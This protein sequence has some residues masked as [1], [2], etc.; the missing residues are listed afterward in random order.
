MKREKFDVVQ[1][2]RNFTGCVVVEPRGA[3]GGLALL[4][5]DF[6]TL[7]VLSS[8]ARIVDVEVTAADHPPFFLTWVYGDP[9][10]HK[11]KEVWD[12]ITSI[13]GQRQGYKLQYTCPLNY[14]LSSVADFIDRG[15]RTWRMDL[16][17]LY[18]QPSDREAI[19]K[20]PLS[21]FVA[22]DKRI[23]GPLPN[24][25][26]SVKS[27][28]Q[29]LV[30]MQDEKEA[31]NASSSR[32]RNWDLVPDSIWKHIWAIRTLPKIKTFIWHA[33][34]EGLATGD[35]LANRKV[36]IDPVCARCGTQ[37]ETMGHLLFE[38]SF[39]RAIWFGSSLTHSPSFTSAPSL[40]EWL[41]GWDVLFRKDKGLARESLA[42]ASF[43]CWYIWRA[44]NDMAH[45]PA[46]SPTSNDKACWALPPVGVLKAN[47]DAVLT[48]DKSRGGLGVIFR[49]HRGVQMKALSI[50]FHL[51]SVLQ[52]EAA[53]VQSALIQALE[54]GH[55]RLQVEF[56]SKELLSFLLDPNRV[57]PSEAAIM[58][59]DVRRLVAS[60]MSI[61]FL[62]IPRDLNSI[63]DTLARK[64]L[65]IMCK[66]DW[67][68][69]IPW[70]HTLC[71]NEATGCTHAFDQ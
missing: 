24:G 67:P 35:G 23:W 1:R 45:A 29:M 19:L 71:L 65:S 38:C 64:A 62:C 51:S 56:D 34:N 32:V 15:N 8:D 27:A 58:I 40:H 61:S 16:L 47:C 39:S 66:I 20:I 7:N 63:A 48:K 4:W 33:W 55:Q 43:I 12:R 53:A 42:K 44:R 6:V 22:E 18:F 5:N 54:D 60:F 37:R 3:S 25:I 9:L 11:R 30:K 59:A 14:H 57:P 10:R 2:K 69:T 28:Y 21:L 49:D 31:A 50:P 52:G 70:L 26:F 46:T 17:Q 13:G 41:S 68:L 36:P